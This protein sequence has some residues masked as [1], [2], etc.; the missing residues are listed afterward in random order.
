MSLDDYAAR[1]LNPPSFQ[2][3][4]HVKP[5]QDIRTG[6]DVV[7]AYKGQECIVVEVHKDFVGVLFKHE[8]DDTVIRTYIHNWLLEKIE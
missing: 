3:G 4:D 5:W 6:L 2:I 7:Y 8:V 1:Y